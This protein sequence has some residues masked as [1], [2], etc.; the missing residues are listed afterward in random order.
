[1]I[2]LEVLKTNEDQQMFPPLIVTKK[3]QKKKKKQLLETVLE[4]YLKFCSLSEGNL[5]GTKNRISAA[6]T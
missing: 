2:Y 1:M 4:K 3:R 5:R 6:G